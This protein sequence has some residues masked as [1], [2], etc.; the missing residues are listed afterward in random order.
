[1]N[2]Q[3][4]LYFLSRLNLT[5]DTVTVGQHEVNIYELLLLEA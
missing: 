1:M 3:R 2:N 4:T 5:A